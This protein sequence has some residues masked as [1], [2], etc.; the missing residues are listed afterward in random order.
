[1]NFEKRILKKTLGGRRKER[2]KG[3]R[4]GGRKGWREGLTVGGGR[5]EG[6]IS[7]LQNFAY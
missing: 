5:E 2:R 6:R 3:G 1:M 7:R 4:D